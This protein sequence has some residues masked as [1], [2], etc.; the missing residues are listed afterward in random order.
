MGLPEEGTYHRFEGQCY[1]CDRHVVYGS[2]RP[3]HPE[4][5]LCEECEE[6]KMEL[7]A[8]IRRLKERQDGSVR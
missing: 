4:H 2:S 5:I 1:R 3:R 8:E 6:A 7:L